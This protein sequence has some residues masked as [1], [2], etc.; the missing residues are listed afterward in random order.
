M[1]DTI[2]KVSKLIKHKQKCLNKQTFLTFR[3]VKRNI[4]SYVFLAKLQHEIDLLEES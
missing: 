2:I 1:H 3:Q 4:L